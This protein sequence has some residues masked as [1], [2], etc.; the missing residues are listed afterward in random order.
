MAIHNIRRQQH[1]TARSRTKR[2][3][4]FLLFPIRSMAAVIKQ[5]GSLW[6][7]LWTRSRDLFI[8]FPIK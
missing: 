2:L 5:L 7:R 6:R 1:Y 3:K 8:S 4:D